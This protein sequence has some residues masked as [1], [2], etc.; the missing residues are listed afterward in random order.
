MQRLYP[1][2]EHF[3]KSR[4]VADLDHREP[5]SGKRFRRAAGGDKRYAEAREPLR[6]FDETR[7]VGDGQQRL[8]DS[9]GHAL[10][11]DGGAGGGKGTIAARAGRRAGARSAVASL[12]TG[13][14]IPYFESLARSVLRFIPSM[15]A[16]CV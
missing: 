4:V 12:G 11:A 6:E 14:R 3:R 5:C 2:I 10:G 8:S 7:L 1:A 9:G 16:A 15:S 13:Y